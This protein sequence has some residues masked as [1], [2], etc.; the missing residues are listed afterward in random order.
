MDD[1]EGENG[2][3]QQM[4]SVFEF[5]TILSSFFTRGTTSYYE[6]SKFILKL[7]LFKVS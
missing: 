5:F 4:F 2:C 3:E 1:G 6:E 7:K